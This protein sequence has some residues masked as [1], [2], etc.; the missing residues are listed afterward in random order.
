[1]SNN[2]KVVGSFKGLK[3]LYSDTSVP[4]T[5]S[6]TKVEF[7][8]VPH[9]IGNPRIQAQDRTKRK[10]LKIKQSDDTADSN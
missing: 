8:G 2:K 3:G 10:T 4:S 6:E 1:M 9:D 5:L 7:R